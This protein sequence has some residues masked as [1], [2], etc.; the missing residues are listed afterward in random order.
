MN[1]PSVARYIRQTE[2]FE[3]LQREEEV[4]LARAW[5]DRRDAKA[6]EKLVSSHLRVVVSIAHKYRRYGNPMD[7][8]IAEGNMGL[9][10]ALDKFDPE[11]SNRFVTYASFWVRA[12]VVNHV[13][14]NWSVARSGRGPLRSKLF[15]KLRRERAKALSQF[16]DG[17]EHEAVLV[18]RLG[19]DREKLKAMFAT[20]DQHDVSLDQPV[21]TEAATTLGDTL[22]SASVPSDEVVDEAQRHTAARELIELALKDLDPREYFIAKHRLMADADDELTLAELGRHLGVTRE[23]ARQLEVRAKH[24]L[25]VRLERLARRRG[26]RLA[27]LVAA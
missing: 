3:R 22:A 10:Q 17:P 12:R 27:E 19:F 14:N 1:S 20:L 4:A 26:G 9:L 24:K 2:R 6:A 25:K 21:R 15:F 11:R 23:R 13:L 7:D 18:E 16:G 5:R 8:L